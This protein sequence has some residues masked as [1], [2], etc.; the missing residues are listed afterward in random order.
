M[1]TMKYSVIKRKCVIYNIIDELGGHYAK[2]N[3]LCSERQTPHYLIYIWNFLE[4]KCKM[5]IT[6]GCRGGNIEEILMK[7]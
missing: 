2:G 1:Y 7:R 4:I 6:R 3:K 5:L